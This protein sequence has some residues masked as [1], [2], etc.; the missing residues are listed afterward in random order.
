M[1]NFL[2]DPHI[3]LAYRSFGLR[4]NN[5]YQPEIGFSFA[6]HS[7]YTTNWERKFVKANCPTRNPSAQTRKLYLL[8]HL[9]FLCS[10]KCLVEVFCCLSF[11]IE[12]APQDVFSPAQQAL[13][14]ALRPLE[15][16]LASLECHNS[17]CGCEIWSPNL[18]KSMTRGSWMVHV[19]R[20]LIHS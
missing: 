17:R 18:G 3:L 14:Q 9:F 10:R 12:C 19:P 1:G 5:V 8:L 2:L 13:G 20:K 4:Y 16:R 11:G 6:R 15:R 7:S